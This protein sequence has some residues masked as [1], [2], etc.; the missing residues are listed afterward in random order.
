MAVTSHMHSRSSDTLGDINVASQLPGQSYEGVHGRCF[1]LRHGETDQRQGAPC[2]EIYSQD[3]VDAGLNQAPELQGLILSLGLC[4]HTLLLGSGFRAW[5]PLG[6]RDAPV[7]TP[8]T[9]TL[10]LADSMAS[11]GLV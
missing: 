1:H 11:Y 7:S 6:G 5:L 8:C 9:G 4:C 3:V 2:S 10:S